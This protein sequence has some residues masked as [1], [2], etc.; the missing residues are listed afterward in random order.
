MEAAQQAAAAAHRAAIAAEQAAAAART[1][2][3]AF[4]HG[5]ASDTRVAVIGLAGV[6]I[7]GLITGGL[8]LWGEERKR[9]RQ[10]QEQ[11]HRARGV[12]RALHD[13]LSMWLI[14]VKNRVEGEANSWWEAAQEPSQHW[15]SDDIQLVASSLDAEQWEAVRCAM[16]AARN[17]AAN[18]LMGLEMKKTPKEFFA[19]PT[20]EI[21]REMQ[22]LTEGSEVLV[23]VFG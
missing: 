10:Q 1:A 8:Q 22:W 2:S 21:Q 13:Y 9:R 11:R 20:I 12:S 7:G 15:D 19:I 3:G 4:E 18:R 17:V 14:M 16:K 6:L 5:H 23:E